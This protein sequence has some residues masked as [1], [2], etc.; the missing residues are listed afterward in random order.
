MYKG[1]PVGPL[2]HAWLEQR[3][4]NPLVPG[5]TPGRPTTI[6]RK[7]KGCGVS[8]PFLLALKM[9]LS[10][11]LVVQEVSITAAFPANCAGTSSVFECSD[12]S[13]R[14]CWTISYA[15]LNCLRGYRSS[16]LMGARVGEKTS[17]K[18]CSAHAS[19]ACANQLASAL[20]NTVFYCH[21]NAAYR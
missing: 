16:S 9:A 2:A 6:F 3:T 15:S 18:A 10:R 13:A 5:S 19:P 11:N 20:S 7:S 12:S 21:S 14:S 4:H 1:R 17:L 8:Q